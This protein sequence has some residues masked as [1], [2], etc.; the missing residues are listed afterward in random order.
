MRT[1]LE[2]TILAITGI[3][4]KSAEEKLKDYKYR[5]VKIDGI[6]MIITRDHKL[7]RLNLEIENNIIVDVYGG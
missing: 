7:E 2:K 4:L 1:D 3:D 5:I 6:G